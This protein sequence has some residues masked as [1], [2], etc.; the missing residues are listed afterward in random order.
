MALLYG[1]SSF[2]RTSILFWL[3]VSLPRQMLGHPTPFDCRLALW[4]WSG[5]SR[6]NMVLSFVKIPF[7]ANAHPLQV[8]PGVCFLRTFEGFG[9]VGGLPFPDDPLVGSRPGLS[10]RA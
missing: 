9:L 6:T 10:S 3:S 1:K 4:T 5:E 8:N 7:V 2:D